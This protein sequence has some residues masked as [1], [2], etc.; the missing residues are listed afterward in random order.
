M[1]ALRPPTEAD[2]T[3]VLELVVARD[4]ADLG[5]PDFTLEDVHADWATPG[6][7]LANDARV[8]VGRDGLEGYA[9]LLGDV[10]TVLVHPAAEGRGVGSALRAW[11][12]SRAAGRGVPVLKQF[13]AGADGR[14]D[15][16]LRA[17]GYEPVQRYFRLRADLAQVP[18]A[19]PPG[20]RAFRPEGDAEDVHAVVQ[21]AFAEVEG[22][23]RQDL[24]EW[25]ARRMDREGFEPALWRVLEDRDGIVGV[26]VNERWADGEGYVD[27]LAVARRARGRGHGRSLLLASFAAF[28]AAGLETAVLTV[29]G[30][31]R[32]AARLYE[33]VG[34]RPV[35]EA[36]RWELD[37]RA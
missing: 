18:A 7:S 21:E 11:A 15:A 27:Q 33:S 2:D 26:A 23:A 6:L 4:V 14:A 35:W 20:A 37:L 36:R 10:A 34:M 12:E 17:A 22:S 3:A 5:R 31:N 25:R 8:A 16:L 19:A 13:T 29:H 30:R 24:A 9:I 1:P 28:R 32:T